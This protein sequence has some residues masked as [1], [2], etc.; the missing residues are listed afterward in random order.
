MFALWYTWF[1]HRTARGVAEK[2]SVFANPNQG[3]K[4]LNEPK[5]SLDLDFAIR[6]LSG[7]STSGWKQRA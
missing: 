5:V 1:T 3:N 6:E 4:Q 7:L 2:C